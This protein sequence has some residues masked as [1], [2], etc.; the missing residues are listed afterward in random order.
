MVKVNW[1]E[2]IQ[3]IEV[4]GG[5]LAKKNLEVVSLTSSKLMTPL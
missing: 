4:E 3:R 5:L 2:I 1:I